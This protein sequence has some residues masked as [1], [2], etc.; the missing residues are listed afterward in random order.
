M[1]YNTLMGRHF[2]FLWACC[3][4][5]CSLPIWSGSHP[6]SDTRFSSFYCRTGISVRVSLNCTKVMTL[7]VVMREKK[8]WHTGADGIVLF[9]LTDGEK[10]GIFADGEE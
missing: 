9:A 10:G 3:F 2:W 8:T 7:R 6:V 5:G 1:V 4:R